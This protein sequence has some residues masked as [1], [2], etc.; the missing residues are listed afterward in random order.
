MRYLYAEDNP[1]DADLLCAHF[2]MFAPDVRIEVVDNGSQCLQT[3][4]A[5]RFDLLL[6]DN[7]LPDMDGLTL[8]RK[9]RA[10]GHAMP[11]V[12]ITGDG[13]DM[14]I[15][16]ALQDGADDYVP[17]AAGH[18]DGL[19]E[20]LAAVLRRHRSRDLLDSV[21]RKRE[22]RVLYIEPNAMDVE[23]TFEHFARAAPDLCLHAVASADR[24][25]SLLGDPSAFDLVLTDL[26]LSGMSA[27]E[28]MRETQHRGMDL[29]FVIITG[30]GDETTVVA[31]L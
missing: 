31:L 19:P 26:R 23:L 20:L 21:D 18:L 11:V 9:V 4:A 14:T 6:L 22:H 3:L 27:M 13:D 2:A 24:A 12:M 30:R 15:W 17:K 7:H 29:P 5:E 8:L 28:L 1:I 16:R 10:A 25:L